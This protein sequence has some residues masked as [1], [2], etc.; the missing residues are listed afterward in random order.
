VSVRIVSQ[1]R[2]RRPIWLA[3]LLACAAAAL[4][5]WA[6]ALNGR[7]PSRHQAEHW[8]IA[9]TGFDL[10][11]AAVLLSTGVAAL[12]GS[13]HV[14]ALAAAAAAMLFCDAW[15]DV[16]TAH[17]R[18]ELVVALVEAFAAEL[19]LAALCLIVARDPAGF[20]KKH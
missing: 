19:P 16:L 3:G 6:L 8:N 1:V 13:R 14:S 17:T 20:V 5:P 18:T 7:L 12:R 11:L 10:A 4:V 2:R 15:F 9:W